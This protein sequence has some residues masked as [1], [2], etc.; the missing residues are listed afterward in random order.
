MSPRLRRNQS[1]RFQSFLDP[2]NTRAKRRDRPGACLRREQ[3][4]LSPPLRFYICMSSPV[5][6]CSPSTLARPIWISW[7]RLLIVWR[8]QLKPLFFFFGPVKLSI[9]KWKLQVFVL[10][11]R[12]NAI[13]SFF[14]ARW[15]TL[16]YNSWD[17][18]ICIFLPPYS[19]SECD[20]AAYRPS[21]TRK[22][23]S[24]SVL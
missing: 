17:T 9:K 4:H 2:P 10:H 14:R 3:K 24:E 15:W 5:S 19:C 7:P 13:I 6:S 23:P 21:H 12:K 11:T 22:Y 1:Y 16:I 8:V 18:C 20:G